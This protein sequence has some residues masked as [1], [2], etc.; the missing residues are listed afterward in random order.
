[1]IG[2]S[3]IVPP[4]IMKGRKN[5]KFKKRRIYFVREKGVDQKKSKNVKRTSY[6]S[7][8]PKIGSCMIVRKSVRLMRLRNVRFVKRRMLNVREMM[9]S[10]S[11]S[12]TVSYRFV[13]K[14][15][16]SSESVLNVRKVK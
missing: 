4:A 16:G 14:I 6:R 2:R 11:L 12:K 8:D 3:K 15:V 10:Q 1:M 5:V 13:R 7:V 9:K